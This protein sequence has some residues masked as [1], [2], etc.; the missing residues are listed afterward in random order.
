M[1]NSRSL[2]KSRRLKVNRSK[3]VHFCCVG[4]SIIELVESGVHDFPSGKC[5]GR[6]RV[7][8]RLVKVGFD[9]VVS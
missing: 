7:V 8:W 6:V 3:I 2:S 4:R 5:S 1:G 9:M